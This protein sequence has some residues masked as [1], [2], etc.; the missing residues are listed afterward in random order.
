MFDFDNFGETALSSTLSP[1]DKA[2]A[3]L[4]AMGRPIAGRLLKY[5]TQ[6][7][8]QAIIHSAQ[9]LRQIPPQEL[10]EL[11]TDY[12]EGTLPQERREDFDAHLLECEGCTN[13]LAE[14]RHTISLT[15]KL[16]EDDLSPEAKDTLLTRSR[17]F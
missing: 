12:L 10:V 11:V 15:G 7:E 9:R 8:L 6:A 4:L 16:S 2:A 1:P 13:Y 3:V 5:F 17:N 14:M